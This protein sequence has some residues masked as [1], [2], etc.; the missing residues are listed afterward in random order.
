MP[1]IGIMGGT[2]DPIHIGHLIAAEC[3]LVSCG[4]DEVW[5]IP[6]ASP[7]LKNHAPGASSELRYEMVCGAVV[8]NPRFRVNDIELRRSGVS[9]SIDTATELKK[10]HPNHAFR[11][12]IGSDRIND[13]QQWHRIEA[14]ASLV[15][16]IGLE[17]PTD[18]PRLDGLPLY[19]KQ[20][21]ELIPMPLIGISSTDLRNRMAAGEAVRYQLSEQTYQFIRRHGLYGTA[22]DD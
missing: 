6:S 16:F 21:V 9:Y 2:F 13:L 1:E 15:S 12:I 5:F 22:R 10:R 7:P 4:L 8:S 18:T 14:L 20:R 19:L 3:A 11:Y 17:R